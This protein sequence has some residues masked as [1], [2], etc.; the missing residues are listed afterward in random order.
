MRIMK[1]LKRMMTLFLATVLVCT[2]IRTT[3]GAGDLINLNPYRQVF[4]GKNLNA[5]GRTHRDMNIYQVG[6]GAGALPALCIQ[7]GHKLPDGSPA[8]Y[9]QYYVEP[10]KPVPVIGPFE[11]YLSMV[12]AY[13]WLV[14]DN[15]YVPARYGVV[16][17]YYWGCMNGYEHNWALQKQAMEKFQAVMNGDPMVMVYYEEMKAHILEGEAQFNGTGSSSLPAWTGSVQKMTLKDGHYELTLDISSCPQLQDTSWSFPDNQWLYKLAPDGRSVTFQYNG[18]QEPQGTIMSAQIQG[19]ENR[20]YAY[21]FTPAASENL[22]KQLGWLDFNRPMA[23]VSFSVGTDAVLPGSSDLELYRHSETFQSNYNI[24]LEKYCAE[25]N[26]PLE[27]TVFNVWE[28]FDFSQVNEQGYEEGEP[29][30]TSGQVYLNCMSPEPENDYVCDILTTDP[31]GYARHSD[32]RYYNY[33]KTYCMGHPAPE[34]TECDHEEDEDC[35]CDEE[36]DR[37]RGQWRAEQEL[38]AATCDFHALN[39]DEDN[40]EQDTSAMEAML[41]DRDETYERFIE[42]EYSY[43]LQ[44][45]T[46]RTGYILHGLHNDD[47]EIETV[48]LSA[49]QAGGSARP[50]VYRPGSFVGK[51]VEPVYTYVAAMRERRAY[52]YPVPDAQE[53]E[54]GEQRS[55]FS[56][57][58]DEKEKR[59]PAIPAD[60][61]AA[62]GIFGDQENTSGSAGDQEAGDGTQ[63]EEENTSGDGGQDEDGNGNPE[64]EEEKDG[65]LTEKNP[66]DGN[67]EDEE[68]GGTETGNSASG[69]AGPETG[70][71]EGGE[72]ETENSGSGDAEPETGNSGSGGTG[73]ESTGSGDAGSEAGNSGSGGTGPE[74]TGSGGAGPETGNSGSEGAGPE[75]T[76]SGGAGPEARNTGSEG[77]GP[78]NTGSGGPKSDGSIS[79]KTGDS[80]QKNETSY[81]EDQDSGRQKKEEQKSGN[82]Q[83]QSYSMSASPIL[84]KS[85][86]GKTILFSGISSEEHTVNSKHQSQNKPEDTANEN[87][88]YETDEDTKKEMNEEINKDTNGKADADT[89]INIEISSENSTD[90]TADNTADNA[91]DNTTDNTTDKEKHEIQDSTTETADIRDEAEGNSHIENQDGTSQHD[92]DEEDGGQSQI[93][94]EYEYARNPISPS[95]GMA[96]YFQADTGNGDEEPEEEGNRAVRF[97]RSL[98]SGEEDDDDTIS[99]SLP[100][101][102]D[103]DLG[104]LDVSA[105]GEPDTILYTFK[106]WDHR[107]E[108]RLHINKRDLELY[109]ADG[110]K[111]YGLTQG[112][113]TLE[114]A[115]YGLFAAQDIIHP[116]GKSGTIYNQNDLT[117]VA[118]T[119]K[120]GNASF[121]A[122]T[123]KPGTR[124]SDDG[125]IIAPEN[126]TG[127]E[128]LY[129]GSSVTSSAQGFGTVVYPDYVLSNEDQWIGRPLIMGSYYVMELSRSEGYELSV[130]GISL[131]ESN[132]TQDIVNRIHEAGQARIS[133]GLSDYNS[134]DADGSWND[135]IV[136]SY[137]TENGYDII[138]TGYPQGAE[139]YEIRTGTETKTYKAVLGSSLQPKVDQQGSPVYQTAKGGEYKIGADGNPIIR[140]DTATDSDTGERTPYGETL[141]YRFRTAP[142]PSGTAV[143]A[144]MSKWGQAIEPNYLSKQVNGML[145]QLGYRPVTDISPWTQIRLSGQTNA[146][147]AEEIMDWYT[148][149]NF[150][151]CGYVEDIYEIEGSFF[152]LL[153]HDYSLGHAGFPAVYDFVNRKLYVRKTAEVSGGPAGKVGYWIEYQKGEYSLK[154]A[155][156]SIKEK[157]EINQVIPFG[158]DIE[159][160]AETVYQPLYETYSEGDIVLDR[161]GNPIP[162]MERVYEYE[163]RTET[164]EID[165]P[166][167]VSAVYDWATGNYAVHVENTIDWKD[168]TEPEYTEFRVVTREKAIDWEGEELPYSQYL[169]DIAGAG[170]SA[171]AAVP[172][173]DE[174][175]YVV[176]QALNY[177]GQNQPVQEAGTGSSPL[178]VLQRVIKQSVKVTKDIS[179]S[180]YDGVNTYGSVHND[181]LT[182]L[183]G[184][185]NGGSS[186]QGAK[187]LNQFKFKAYL[188]SNLENIF[189]DSAGNIISED[190]GTAD[191]KGD[192]QKIFLPPRDGSGQRLLETKEDGSYDYTKFFDAMYAAVQVEKGKKPQEAIQQFAVDY[193]DID[194]YK[195][196]ILTAEPGL[197]SDT[198][199]EKAL[200]RAADEA[201]SYLSVFSGLDNRL[202]IAWDSD[203]GGGADGDVTT[204]QCNTRNGKDDYFNHSIMLA[205]GTYVIVEQ[206]PA[207]VDRELANRHFTRDYP[208]E[209]TLP[210]VPDIGQDEGTGETDVNYQ[211]G[212]PYFRYDSTDTPDDLIRKY[213]I[214]FNEET[215]I[216]Q[217][218]GQDGKFEI[219]KYGLDKDMR[220]GRSLTSQAPYEE[221][222]MDG[223]NDTVKG[224]YAGYTS[225]SEDAGIMDGVIYDGYETEDGQWEVR[226]QV[227]TMKGMQTAVDGK[228]ASM[229]VPWTVLPPAVDRINP[230]T[231]NVETLIPSGNGRDFN[232]VA[233][234]QEDF[235]DEYFNSRLRIEKLDSETGDSIIHEGALF[236]IYAAKREVEKEGMGTVTGSGNVLYG[237]AVDWQGNPVADADGR[238]ILYPRVGKNNG[239][240]DDLPVRLDKDG[241]PQYDESQ[242]IRQEDQEGNETGVFRAYS[243]IRELVV[244]GQVKKVPVG[245][246]ETYKPLGAGVYVLVEIQAP[247]GYGKSRPVAF[248]V[249]A[250]NVS[251]Y[252][253][254]RNADGTT[255]GWEEETAVRYQYA[256]PVAGSTNKVRTSTVSRIKV[257]DYPSRMEI[258]K[259][260]DGDSL[261]GNQNI[262]QKTDDQGRVESSGGFET[263]VTVNDAGDLLVYKVSGR[264]EKLEERG[265]VRDIAYNPKTMQWDGY[266]TKSFDEY[267]EHI[268]EGTEKELKAMSGVK[269]L[270]RLDG[271]FTGRGIRF[272]ISVS[273][274]VL[275]LYHA[276][277]IEKTGEH[278]YKGVSASVKDGKV[279]RIT[280]TN[281]GTHKEIRVVGE[282]NSPGGAVKTHTASWDV[283]DAVIV[284]NDP[285]NL[286]FHDLTQVD[287]REDPDTGE[288]LVLDKK[289]NPLCFADSVTGMAYV[290]DDYGRM[291]A[292]TADDE[293]N[294][295]L[296]KSIQVLKDENGQTIYDNKTTVDDENGLPIY[297]I[298]GNVVTKDESWTTDSSMDS[299]GTQE[300]SG[301][302]HLI[303]RLPF[304]S[305]ILE[306]QGVPY[307]Q[308]YIQAMYMGL[309]IQDTD[310]VQKYF[311]QNEFTKTAFAKLDVR[312]QKEIRGAVMT[313]YRA[314]LDSDGSP[315]REQD[316]TYKKGQVYASWISGYQYD[317]DGNI[318]LDEHGEPATTTKPHWIDHIPVGYYVLEETISPY[319][320]GYVQSEAVN[321]DVLETGDV[322]SFEME[323]D[324][325]SIDI[326]KY[327]T[328]NGDVI[329]GD[330]EAYLT[331]YRPILDEKGFPVLEHGIPRYDETGRIFT[332]RAATYKDGQDVAATGRVVPDAGGNHPIMKYDYDFREITGTYQGRYYYTEQ[333]TVRLEYLPAGNYVLAETENPEGYATANPI[334]INIEETGHLE[335]I[336]Y[337]QMGDKPLKLE[338]SKVDITGGKEVNGAKLAVYPVDEKGN[339]S[340]IPLVLHQPSEDGQYQDIEAV[341]ISG[342]DGRYTEEDGE[343]GLIPAGFQPG[344]L[345]PHTLEYIPE[346]DYILREIITPYGFL[347]S[348]DIPFTIA[349]SQV[350]QKTEMTDEIPDGILRI[351]K[352]DSD[353]PDEK[354]KGAEFC[355]VNQTTGAICGT[356]TTDQLGQAQFEPQPIGYMDRDG[357]FKPYT[358]VCSETKAAPGHMLTLE[359][360]EFQF[361]YRN[362]LTDLIVWE[363]NPTNDSNRVITDKLSGDTEEMLEGALLR[364][365]RRTESGWETAEEW[366][367]G[368]QGHYT[369]N[370]SEGQ[371]RLIEVKAPEGYKLQETP[372]EFTI[373]DGMTGIPHLV[374]RNYTTIIDVEKTSAE[375]GKLLGGARLQLIDKSDG[376]VIRE[377][378]SEA[379]RGQQF[380]GLKPGTYIIH[381]L[382][383]PSGYERT[384]DRE[385]VVKEWSG[386]EGPEMDQK[387]GNELH[388]MVQVFR[389]ENQT[390]SS[391]GG[392]GG[393]RPRPKAEYITFKKTDVS[394]KVLQGAEFTFYDQTGRV[395]GTSV[396]DSTGTFRIRR[397]DNGTYTFR[398]TKAPGGYALNPGIF[399]FTVN[400]SDVI[401]GAYEVVDKELE[402]T[403][404]KLDGDSGL[405]LMG[406]K[407]RIGKGEN[408]VWD[409][410]PENTGKGINGSAAGTITEAVTGADGTFTCR[411][412][413]PGLYVI[414]ET[415][416]PLGYERSDKVYEF[417]M[418]AEGR[419]QG[420]AVM[421]GSVTI[422]NWKEKPPV[423]KIGSITAV[424]QVGSR[425]G[426]GTYHF[427]SGPRDTVRTGDDLPVAAA[428]AMAVLCMAGFSMCLCM[429]QKREWSKGRK[430]VIFILVLIPVTVYLAFDVLAEETDSISVSGKIVYS[431]MENIEPVPQTAWVLA[432]DEISGKERNVLLPLVSYHFSDKHWE[433]GFRLDLKV[434]DYD[435][436]F[437]EVG[438][439]RIETQKE[440]IRES[441]MDYEA[442]ILGQAGLDSEAY[443]IDQF[444][445]NGGV[446]ESDGVLCRNLTALGRKMVADCTAVYGGEVSR[447]A[448]LNDSKGDEE[449]GQIG[450]SGIDERYVIKNNVQPFFSMGVTVPAAGICFVALIA[451]MVLAMIKNTRPYGMAAVMFMFFAGVVFSMHFLV[452]MGMDYADGRRI[453]GMVQDEAYGRGQ[454]GEA[455]EGREA[456]EEREAGEGREAGEERE[457][458][459]GRG[460]GGGRNSDAEKKTDEESPDGKSPLN[461]EALASI[462][463]EYQFWLAVPGTNIDYPVVRHE[464]NEYYLN[465]NFY[466][467]QHITGCVFADSSAVPLAV[468]NTVLY[469]HNMKDGSMFAGLKQYGEE[470]FFRENPVI[471]IFYRGKW[472]ECPVFS[473]Q[474]RHQSDAGAYGTNFM[475]EEWLPYLEKMGAASLYETGITP[476][477]DE[478]L[479][480]LS[481]CYGKDQYLIVQALLRGM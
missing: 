24:D 96:A 2:A 255:D 166:E 95:F 427:G 477:G 379:G 284:D 467:E 8:K 365:E 279:T 150:F 381:E 153:R 306:E 144:D 44:E 115:V 121:L 428:A 191:F 287:T 322:Q 311:L 217:A 145:G 69:G 190:I 299:N 443:R 320:Q 34:W 333:G 328:K 165:K 58:G 45:K 123:E 275:S 447:N 426:K 114:G 469:G 194:A 479:I 232:F 188:K 215:H 159:A 385:I 81:R 141:P 99:V 269:P 29:D 235:E 305:Y 94:E 261:V 168:R 281:T 216:I 224:Y 334:L 101:F 391:S 33:S 120:Q 30:G 411:L 380:Y 435:A 181:P 433:D 128:N 36:N 227:A 341:W 90:N 408:R 86:H 343:Q 176:F 282:E 243:T 48:V 425:F 390:A 21:I 387:A 318:K 160:A 163:D 180:S 375:T 241:I 264:K 272:D 11:R 277:E 38:C 347:Q 456:G 57:W 290:Y 285:V 119:D 47:K 51:A 283:W 327:D 131:K 423:R 226:D 14:S 80:R 219:Y 97:I 314:G 474:I 147:A 369:K 155:V 259:V 461:E 420:E 437:Y 91:A 454:E 278:V 389:F 222:Y 407:F 359:P 146:Q 321:I 214:R 424:Y 353:K 463:P 465:H 87:I 132:R 396:S 378:T 209:I 331:L 1:T 108:G 82:L 197:N 266:V 149:H 4:R 421:Q 429:K 239:S 462:N 157:R 66:E 139:F 316:G 439:V 84:L 49:A 174:G 52:K 98:F 448:F 53:M 162:L 64:G 297:Y 356:V 354:L 106:V 258:H 203:A 43:H 372:I 376:R 10:G 368:R 263:D 73:P 438:G 113:A 268:V 237:E 117:A 459:E 35:S 430:W 481:T 273:G 242:L 307:D 471:Q 357:N 213:K 345:K 450:D 432:R 388:N 156:A 383:A 74:S 143:P 460:A 397:P 312:T 280:D 178:Q 46:A 422:Y 54:L 260:E 148:V 455:G 364:I 413:T 246:I 135:F 151:D 340:E 83:V 110:D 271:T 152:A 126:A 41:A 317:D 210:F 68:S 59:K 436:G 348:V 233:F 230:D 252:R 374:M 138:L 42:L 302:R 75:S 170:V 464:D 319:E 445:W 50:A 398:E 262:L 196:E 198:A 451:A 116:D 361:H 257:E 133:G 289:G 229:L 270:Y 442:E 337:F 175:S 349:D 470:A 392:G 335:E 323:D 185:F 16:Q 223:R 399:S 31:D 231:G 225:Q 310:Q 79:E 169:T 122:Y 102:M 65:E 234:A 304:G 298:S 140:P 19:I 301:A 201:G 250:D 382:Q 419:I 137:K 355:L 206:V 329:Y 406:A 6:E 440:E 184:L 336:Q 276:M 402:F 394:G 172:P 412:A 125:T 17:V 104:A 360:Y 62:D 395:I 193:Y 71:S 286:Y 291:L 404:T 130:N 330:S 134:M 342:L 409:Q 70:N 89:E 431:S 244:D 3:S 236:K 352:S 410:E 472:V 265:D 103:D 173:V 251:F 478:K 416:A 100:S 32:T 326:L 344:D 78:E 370:L 351:I 124:L 5:F 37:L 72:T 358:Y 350:L 93:Y 177:P 212:S 111:S 405:P 371:Y 403:V 253:E 309:V 40:R 15:Y 452:K 366:V 129:N 480:T 449:S 183:L 211:T 475:E 186:S 28:D 294:K 221:E 161:E 393:N 441:L 61:A 362:E 220:P 112:D 218:N 26:Q 189:V 256:I 476:G 325:T 386:T 324:F 18:N 7:E 377:W 468:D 88:K 107:T 56:L 254:R 332:F 207:D 77:T 171:L 293:G 457:A 109:R 60:G 296:V 9:E 55:I 195:A 92:G 85:S 248:E 401:R 267:S 303:A 164:Y 473:C 418:D 300:T 346:G 373:S 240:T 338:V 76:G 417:T 414:R 23:S 25:T 27:G 158:S 288:L 339:V 249:Y 400:G 238:R 204:L 292:Y 208:R 384:E 247:K 315:H 313:L 415:E 105:Y 63:G 167:P 12:L 127:P 13:E 202:A 466:Q 245:Y 228:F 179:Q 22:Q 205:Y 446:Y 444:Q 453:Y 295:I 39:N 182:V 274:A 118:A 192:V 67:K 363:Y 367:S 200:L 136:E 20:F 308:G 142:Y 458:G 187:L 434:R 199:Y 154:S